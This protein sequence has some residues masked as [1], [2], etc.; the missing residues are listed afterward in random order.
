MID[1]HSHIY[2]SDF[3]SDREKII[4]DAL[5]AGV[6]NILLPNIDAESI[7]R[8]LSVESLF[9]N[10]CKSMIGLHPSSVKNDWVNK[11]KIIEKEMNRGNYIAIG[12]IGIDLY[13]DTTYANEQK[14]A[15]IKQF[16]WAKQ[17]SLPVVIHTRNAF[18]E[19]FDIL[20][21]EYDTRLKGVFHSFSGSLEDALKIIEIP[22]FYL[23]INGTVTYKNSKLSDILLKTGFEKLLLETDA[24]YL[25]PVPYRGKRNEP[26]FLIKTAEKLADIFSVSLT[27]IDRIT[28]NNAEKLFNLI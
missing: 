11:L 14:E 13:W 18:N 10:I 21:K 2:L 15:L 1:T 9:P 24:P 7:N 8:M 12:E 17:K 16:E 25:P 19:I 27:E 20:N 3:D 28:T 5:A 26:S 23:G 22:H 6:T 4:A